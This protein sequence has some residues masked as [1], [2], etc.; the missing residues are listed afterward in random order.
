MQSVH[1]MI[2]QY[3][4]IFQMEVHIAKNGE[5]FT[6]SHSVSGTRSGA[7]WAWGGLGGFSG[8][9]SDAGRIQGRALGP[10]RVRSGFGG[11]APGRNLGGMG[12]VFDRISL[13][14]SISIQEL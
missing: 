1:V 9:D 2:L 11:G 14:N 4:P 10:I 7:D 3:N 13:H 12:R 5:T 8:V 6:L